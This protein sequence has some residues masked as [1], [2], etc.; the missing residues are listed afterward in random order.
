M[1]GRRNGNGVGRNAVPPTDTSAGAQRPAVARARELTGAPIGRSGEADL[2][3]RARR[4]AA[5]AELEPAAV[6]P[7]GPALVR[8]EARSSRRPR[9]SPASR[10]LQ[11]EAAGAR[12]LRRRSGTG[13]ATCRPR[14]APRAAAR[15]AGSRP[16]TLVVLLRVLREVE[17]QLVV[18]RAEAADVL[19]ALGAHAVGDEAAVADLGERRARLRRRPRAARWSG[20]PPRSAG[21]GQA[22]APRAPSAARRRPGPARRRAV[23]APR[24]PG[25]FTTSGTWISSSKRLRPCSHRPWSRNS[26]PWS[27]RNTT[28]ASS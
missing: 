9:A 7:D 11:R 10:R 22:R 8:A 5:R 26:S 1:S 16:A 25:N 27:A 19:V 15:A 2:A 24:L 13:S 28:S 21:S 18:V 17:V 4:A 12:D 14:P 3:R 23:P 20:R 6:A